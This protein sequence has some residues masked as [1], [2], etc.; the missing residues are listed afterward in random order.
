M[1]KSV[2]TIFLFSFLF[3]SCH[4]DDD[5]VIIEGEILN[6]TSTSIISSF[7]NS[8][9][10][11]V[12]TIP[13][14]LSSLNNKGR[15]SFV[16]HIDTN[17]ILTLYFDDFKHSTDIFIEKG[18]NKI[19]LKGD[20]NL[21]DLIDVKGGE[22]NDKISLFKKENETALKQRSL[23]ISEINSKNDDSFNPTNA[24][25]EKEQ[26]AL[27]NSLNHEL[28][29][30]VEDFILLYP[31][32]IASVILIN[33]FFKNNENPKN[34]NRVLKYLKD[35][36]LEHPLTRKLKN[37]NEKLMLSTEGAIMPSFSLTDKNGKD[38]YSTDFNN[39][40]LL[41]SFL[42]AND[43]KSKDNL[44]VLKD[45]YSHL[46]KDSIEF[47]S[48][49]IDTDTFPIITTEI[50]SIPWKVAVENKSWSSDIVELYNISYLPYNILINSKGE[51]ETRD[52]PVVEVK[53]I[54]ESQSDKPKS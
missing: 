10:I 19:K 14:D 45:E 49:Y 46:N 44:S 20:A 8:D 39:K 22:I 31:D 41:I 7:H 12:D 25:S 29:Q 34:L 47:L 43:P 5:K 23:L 13:V 16:Q 35:D 53:N 36:A 37:F 6:L 54:I 50:D 28:A 51:I 38:I 18:V 1:L 3:S 24:I 15:F 26:I 48:I 4:H 40:Y 32:K 42:S 17:R 11:V 30:K 21:P 9:S 33:E 52:A 27:L 2:L